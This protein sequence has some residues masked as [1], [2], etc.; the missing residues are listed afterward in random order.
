M[1]VGLD[2]GSTT[3]KCVVLDDA[4]KIVYSTYE[5]HFSHIVEKSEELLRRMAQ[6][7]VPGGRALFSIS[8]SAGM[9]NKIR[10]LYPQANITAIDYDPSATRV[11]QENRIK[12][13]LAVGR[14][15]LT[16][17]EETRAPNAETRDAVHR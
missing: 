4:D 10:E 16:A 1:K 11:N 7:Y 3:I 15:R 8:G 2:V 6:E 13:M 9:I 12:L 14:E 5:R 17:G